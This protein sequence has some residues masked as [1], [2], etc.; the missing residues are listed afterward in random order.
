ML[1]FETNNILNVKAEVLVNS[2]NL[3]GV[4][5]KGIALAMKQA[6]PENYK[7]YKKACEDKEIDIGKIFVTQTGQFFP[8]YI[9]NF[10]TKKHWRHP[11]KYEWIQAGLKSLKNWLNENKV[12]SIAIPP[13]GSGNGKLEWAVVKKMIVS[14]LSEFENSIDIIVLEPS[15][16]F[17][18]YKQTVK[19]ES[20]LTPSR[21]MLL[22]I[23]S[24]YQVMGYGINLLVVQ[25]IAYF[26]QRMGEPLRLRFEKG[27]YGP[28]AYNLIP[29]LKALS[30]DYI[31]YKSLDDAK[32]S[33]VIYQNQNKIKEINEYYNMFLDEDQKS[34]VE[35]TLDLIRDFETPFGLELLGTIDYIFDQKKKQIDSQSVLKELKDWTERK[36]KLFKKYHIDVAKDRLLNYFNYN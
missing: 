26:L 17:T 19:K 10:P 18:Q 1:S 2:V 8:R 36:E 28:F 13:L 20:K 23:L 12:S 27:Y 15:N 29:V 5:G 30:N 25:K 32:P 16:Q 22:Y 7:L 11:S 33:T 4:M 9:V 14:E 35:R 24:R 31:S 3:F 6:F 34:R 21:A